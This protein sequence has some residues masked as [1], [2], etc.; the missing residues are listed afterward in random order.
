MLTFVV[1][2]YII[3]I[4]FLFFIYRLLFY[5]TTGR[6]GVYKASLDGIVDRRITP[7][8]FHYIFGLGIDGSSRIC[9]GDYSKYHVTASIKTTT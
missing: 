3:L 6:T 1:I 2:N 9:L 5:A 4:L 8:N 7:N